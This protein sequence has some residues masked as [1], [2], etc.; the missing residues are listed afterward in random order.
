[1]RVRLTLKKSETLRVREALPALH[2]AGAIDPFV[3]HSKSEDGPIELSFRLD[4]QLDMK[5]VLACAGLADLA[6]YARRA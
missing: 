2:H 4:D 5:V 3:R 6:P 1:M